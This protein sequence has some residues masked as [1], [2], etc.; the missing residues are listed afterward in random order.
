MAQALEEYSRTQTQRRALHIQANR[1]RSVIETADF[2]GLPQDEV[3]RFGELCGDI[4]A[5]DDALETAADRIDAACREAIYR[6][7][8][9]GDLTR[10]QATRASGI[11]PGGLGVL[12]FLAIVGIGI[13]IA[14]A[15]IALGIG[16]SQVIETIENTRVQQ[17][18][19]DA[20]SAIMADWTARAAAARAAG[21]PAPRPPTLPAARTNPNGSDDPVT[22]IGQT[23]LIVGGAILALVMVTK[24][25]GGR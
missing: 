14:L 4:F 20:A 3:D 2:A 7:Y 19:Y 23:A 8:Q 21:Q 1:L 24:S 9:N 15:V 13:V 5:R 6:A 18:D 17:A 10:E 16:V 25:R 22:K 11:D 12:P